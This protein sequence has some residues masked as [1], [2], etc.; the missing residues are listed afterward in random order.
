M[1]SG[2]NSILQRAGVAK[3]NTEIAGTKEQVQIAILSAISDKSG[4]IT[5]TTL[6]SALKN[7][8]SGVSD[9][10][11]TGNEKYGWQVKIGKKAYSI[12]SSGEVNEAFWEEIRDSNGN[13][14]EIRRVDGT[15]TDLKI[16][17]VIGYSAIDGINDEEKI[18]TSLGTVTGMGEGVDQT[19]IIDAGS[20]RLFGVEK[21]ILK[22][23]STSLVGVPATESD[24]T[25]AGVYA[26]KYLKLQGRI[27]Y[28]NA[29][30]ELNRI[31]SLYGKGKYAESARSIN[32]EDV[33]KTTGYNPNESEY[34]KN[35]I[36]QY[37]NRISFSWNGT[38]DNPQYVSST[39]NGKLSSRHIMGFYWH[40][41]KSWKKSDYISGKKENICNLYSNMYAYYAT[42]LTSENTDEQ[43]GLNTDSIEWDLLFNQSNFGKRN[44]EHYWLA[45]KGTMA[46]SSFNYYDVFTIRGNLIGYRWLATST[47]GGMLAGNGLRPIVYLK[48]DIQLRKDENGVWQFL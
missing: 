22:I 33:N 40:D 3:E 48:S 38:D 41:G 16:G 4:Q 46:Y 28:Q 5:D 14:T 44:V 10:D 35:Q 34:G 23:I 17:D 31:C 15:V 32:V 1:L 19:I 47:G 42:T 24:T 36:Y 25:D 20:W 7:N 45:S 6:R 39:Q 26:S 37:G 43:I 2:D 11:I 29:E 13:V 27:G 21:G 18:I 12:S 30:E 8:L 9:N